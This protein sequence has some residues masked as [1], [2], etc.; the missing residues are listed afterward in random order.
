M[1]EDLI[2]VLLRTNPDARPSAKQILYVPA[3]K[4]YVE[5]FVSFCRDRT[6]SVSSDVSCVSIKAHSSRKLSQHTKTPCSSTNANSAPLQAKETDTKQAVNDCRANKSINLIDQN[7]QSGSDTYEK[8]EDTS[9]KEIS[10]VSFVEEPKQ[11]QIKTE[12]RKTSLTYSE[13]NEESVFK[14]EIEIIKKKEGNCPAR[15]KSHPGKEKM[16]ALHSWLSKVPVCPKQRNYDKVARDRA[17]SVFDDKI[18]PSVTVRRRVMS[19]HLQ[20][21]TAKKVSERNAPF[22]VIQNVASRAGENVLTK[23]LPHGLST[24][25]QDEEKENVSRHS[26]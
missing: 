11:H 10:N 7:S 5:K 22:K 18:A 21:C 23:N 16:A 8:F 9:R 26:Y 24:K 2:S 4:D 19:E 3:M 1:L 14:R 20:K 13:S 6:D 25:Q 12:S 17:L 15:T